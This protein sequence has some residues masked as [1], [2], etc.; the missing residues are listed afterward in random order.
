MIARHSQNRKVPSSNS[1]DVLDRARVSWHLQ[2]ELDLRV[3]LPSRQ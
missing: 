1:T 2:V 3:T